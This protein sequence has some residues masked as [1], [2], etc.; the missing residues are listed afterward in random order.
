MPGCAPLC[1]HS[2]DQ[3]Q[4]MH[5]LWG[6]LGEEASMKNQ[7]GTLAIVLLL[8]V[9]FMFGIYLAEVLT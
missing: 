6:I 2:E 5:D 4:Q 3:A 7:L 8:I 9:A 1:L